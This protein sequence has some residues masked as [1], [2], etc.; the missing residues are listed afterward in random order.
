[1]VTHWCPSNH[2][3]GLITWNPGTAQFQIIIIIITFRISSCPEFHQPISSAL[4]V[5][6]PCLSSHLRTPIFV[7]WGY[8]L[9]GF[10]WIGT[11]VFVLK[12]IKSITNT[13]DTPPQITSE[14]VISKEL[15]FSVPQRQ[16]QNIVNVLSNILI[17]FCGCSAKRPNSQISPSNF[18][19]S[20]FRPQYEF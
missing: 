1:M 10:T 6:S 9:I 16:N 8:G 2:R 7:S 18:K 13:F 11:T 20:V 17:F 14:V 15:M 12:R 4:Q 5:T 19:L 3:C